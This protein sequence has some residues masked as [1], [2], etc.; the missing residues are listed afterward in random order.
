MCCC[1]LLCI[2]LLGERE[3]GPRWID[4]RGGKQRMDALRQDVAGVGELPSWMMSFLF[5]PLPETRQRL[6]PPF[7]V[8]LLQLPCMQLKDSRTVFLCQPCELLISPVPVL[9]FLA[10]KKK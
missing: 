1:V 2:V 3:P 4:P 8:R 7:S 5:F 6:L 9:F 10:Q